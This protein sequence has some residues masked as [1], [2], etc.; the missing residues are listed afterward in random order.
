VEAAAE[1]K[2]EADWGSR[3]QIGAEVLPVLRQIGGKSAN[4][5]FPAPATDYQQSVGKVLQNVWSVKPQPTADVTVMIGPPAFNASARPLLCRE[6][7]LRLKYDSGL[8]GLIKWTEQSRVLHITGLSDF[9]DRKLAAW[10][11]WNAG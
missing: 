6:D 7:M 10:L 9:G 2:P 4:L 8:A 3:L 11:T 1:R 5:V